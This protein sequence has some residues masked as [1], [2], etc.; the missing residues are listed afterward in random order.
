MLVLLIFCCC[1]FVSGVLDLGRFYLWIGRWYF[2]FF[3]VAHNTVNMLCFVLLILRIFSSLN[4]RLGG[5]I[6]AYKIVPDEIEE[7]KVQYY[8]LSTLIFFFCLENYRSVTLES[9]I[10]SCFEMPKEYIA[11]FYYPVWQNLKTENKN[12]YKYWLSELIAYLKKTHSLK[13]LNKIEHLFFPDTYSP[14]F[15][16]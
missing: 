14:S 3:G 10:I 16:W 4:S 13:N 15:N 9:H 1:C 7:I 11:C 6:S 12:D 5:T 8:C 2:L